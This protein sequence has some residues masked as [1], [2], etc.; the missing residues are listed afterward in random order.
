MV[1]EDPVQTHRFYLRILK[2]KSQALGHM[3]ID[4][5]VSLAVTPLFHACQPSHIA[6]IKTA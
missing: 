6:D 4:E 3:I 2:G 1:G 5:T